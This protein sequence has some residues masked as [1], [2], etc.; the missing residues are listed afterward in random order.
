M[1][2]SSDPDSAACTPQSHCRAGVDVTVIDRTGHH[3]FQP[4][5]YQVATGILS[6]GEIAAPAR[7][8]LK[9]QANTK[10]LVSAV[11]SIDLTAGTVTSG[12]PRATARNAV[13][14]PHRFSGAQQSYFG[15]DNFAEHAPG[16]KTIDDALELR[17]RIHRYGSPRR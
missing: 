1:S 11:T 9:N 3:L 17:A 10:V 12:K 4:L 8:S 16:M 15:N 6:E 14:Q 13:R 5:L 7:M 2:L